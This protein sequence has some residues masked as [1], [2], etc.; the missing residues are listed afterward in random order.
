MPEV[1]PEEEPP[2][3]GELMQTLLVVLAVV[4]LVVMLALMIRAVM[5]RVER[6]QSD[7]EQLGD[8]EEIEGAEE[9]LSELELRTGGRSHNDWAEQMCY[10]EAIHALLLSALKSTLR[11]NRDLSAPSLTSREILRG[12]NLDTSGHAALDT[13]VRAAELCVFAR[14]EGTEAMYKACVSAHA[15]LSESLEKAIVRRTSEEDAA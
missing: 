15:T 3:F 5:R 11:H 4:F 13:L 10:E 8:D 9:L 7:R 12:A 2:S 1:E 6:K 14:R